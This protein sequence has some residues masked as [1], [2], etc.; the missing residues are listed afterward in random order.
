MQAT[1]A[2]C[3]NRQMLTVHFD[4]GKS[5]HRR[6]SI[7]P[8]SILNE[9]WCRES[10]GF[11]EL[12]LYMGLSFG[13]VLTCFLDTVINCSQKLKWAYAV[14]STVDSCQCSV[15]HHLKD[16]RPYTIGFQPYLVHKGISLDLLMMFCTVDDEIVCN[17]TPKNIIL[18]SL[19]CLP[20]Q[21][22]TDWW[23]FYC[24]DILPV[25]DVLSHPIN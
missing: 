21:S 11:S 23:F 3:I 13:T 8:Q 6:V 20:K 24:W 18:K 1:H 25:W 19:H 15:Q 7:S 22:F 17:C 5:G 4:G 14:I 2:M 10:G 12:C 9:L 16:Q